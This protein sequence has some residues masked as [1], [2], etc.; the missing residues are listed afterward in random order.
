MDI[1]THLTRCE[2]L[3]LFERLDERRVRRRPQLDS[4]DPRDRDSVTVSSLEQ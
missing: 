1:K 3:D 4:D 2:D